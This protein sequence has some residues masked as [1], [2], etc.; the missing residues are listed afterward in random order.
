MGHADDDL[1]QAELAAALEDLL[2]GGDQ[3]LA[4]IEAEA[5]GASVFAVEEALEQLGGG[6]SLQDRALADV[7]ESGLVVADFDAPLD[8]G[9]LGGILD[10][11]ELDADV[12]AVGL[13]H[14]LH[15]LPQRRRLVAEQVVDV[16]RPLHVGVGEAVGLGI[17]LGM[18][19]ARLQL[20]RIEAGLEVAAHAIS[21][22]QHARADR[23]LGRR[24]HRLDA[25]QP[26][27]DYRRGRESRAV[28][29]HDDGVPTRRPAGSAQVLKHGPAVILEFREEALPTR[30][31]GGGI[32]DVAGVK[33]GNERGVRARQYGG[34]NC[35]HG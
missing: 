22:D 28:A 3:C 10:V 26:R 5:L 29:I 6:E 25:G 27:R 23:I 34:V 14:R 24:L 17:E 11:H 31:D 18:A 8:P 13:A 20:E 30:V 2:Q 4:A 32:F 7:G 1:V 19:L 35:L 16:D 15:D 33:L 9:L 12:A 21:A